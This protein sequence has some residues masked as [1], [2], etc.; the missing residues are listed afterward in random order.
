MAMRVAILLALLVAA[1]P[2]AVSQAPQVCPWLATG[3]AASVLGGDPAMTV[4]SDSNWEGMCR[5]SRQ[6]EGKAST[7]EVR[8]SKVNGHPCPE[9]SLKLDALGN[10]AVQ[11]SLTAANDQETNIIAGRVRDVFFAVCI[12]NVRDVARKLDDPTNP[13][14]DAF[15]ASLLEKVSEQVA[16]SLF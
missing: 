11:C 5:F 12:T 10:E 1:A 7:I 16:G 3:T 2:L 8:V 15:G 9:G 4:H 6:V 14:H 13:P